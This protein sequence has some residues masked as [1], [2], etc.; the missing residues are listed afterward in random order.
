MGTKLLMGLLF[1]AGCKDDRQ[2][3]IQPVI[4]FKTSTLLNEGG[5]Q[6]LKVTLRFTDGDGDIGLS[7]QDT[8]PPY[9]RASPYY[10]NLWVKYYEMDQ[11]PF[12]EIIL[13]SPISARVPV[14]N[15]SGRATPLEGDL[16]YDIDVTLRGNDTLKME[17]QLV[18][19][20]L[21]I[22]APVES[23]VLVIPQ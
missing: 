17:F 3:P 14:L 1:L 10:Y 13:P 9:N 19:R 7:E 6:T 5:T 20:A 11:G 23:G 12:K 18:D 4:S 21:N 2:F 15:S 16:S 22:S 8:F